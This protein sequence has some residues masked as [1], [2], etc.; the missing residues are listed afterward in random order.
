MSREAPEHLSIFSAKGG[1]EEV[2][3]GMGRQGGGGG[4]RRGGGRAH[5]A[6]EGTQMGQAGARAEGH[7]NPGLVD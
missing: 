2:K 4:H 3:R 5:G 1:F 7:G 6:W